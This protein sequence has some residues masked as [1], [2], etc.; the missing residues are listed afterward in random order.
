MKRKT[1]GRRRYRRRRTIRRPRRT[2]KRTYRRRYRRRSTAKSRLSIN[3]VGFIAA[4]RTN[5]KLKCRFL[6]PISVTA[7]T[8]WTQLTMNS[9]NPFG[10]EYTAGSQGLQNQYVN[11]IVLGSKIRV[12]FINLN[13]ANAFDVCLIPWRSGSIFLSSDTP[14]QISENKGA[15]YRIM[16]NSGSNNRCVVKNYRGCAKAMGLTLKEYSEDKA[17]FGFGLPVGTPPVNSPT[18][19]PYW[20][21]GVRSLSATSQT[22]TCVVT[23]T[24]Y[25]QGYQERIYS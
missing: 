1:Y 11:A 24:Q 22:L 14:T 10:T 18:V 21:I 16:G 6:L 23:M 4:D 15:I 8:A 7:S 13:T 17:N 19:R 9:L 2:F 25:T 12:E 20:Y 3:R 5:V